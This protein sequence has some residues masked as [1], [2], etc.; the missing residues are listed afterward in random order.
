M[1][2]AAVPEIGDVLPQLSVLALAVVSFVWAVAA[3]RRRLAHGQPLVPERPHAP[4]IWQGGDVALAVVAYLLVATLIAKVISA[5]APLADR[6]LANVG[7]SLSVAG[8]TIAWLL[9]RGATWH[10]LGFVG[11]H[12]REDVRTAVGGVALVVFPLLMLAAALNALVRYRHPIVDFLDGE[13]DW[14]AVALVIVS[15]VV[16]APLAEE[17]FFRRVLQGWLEKHLASDELA[18]VL[19]SSLA[20]AAAHTGQGLAYV[21][22]FPFSL[23]LGFIAQRTGSIV[24]CILLHALFN[25]VSVVLLL[26]QPVTGPAG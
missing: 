16:V 24:P 25:A 19:L 22:L 1:A 7:L 14:R 6:L 18:P 12:W 13:R 11:G 2:D 3:A 20:F 9:L 15:A 17:L 23:V 8:G 10:E 5:E 26:A 21:P 4:V